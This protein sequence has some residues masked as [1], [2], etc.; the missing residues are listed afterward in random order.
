MLVGPATALFMDE[1]SNGLDSST[2]HQIIM[3]MRHSTHALEGTTVI[4]LLQPSPETYELFDDVIL[5]SE[6]QIIYQGPRDEVLDFFSSLGFSCPERNNVADFLQE[7]IR[8]KEFEVVHC[9]L[10]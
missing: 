1:I 7:V 9:F 5:M 8:F 3:Y 6:G 4:S 10:L 2:T